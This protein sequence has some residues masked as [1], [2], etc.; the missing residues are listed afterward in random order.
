MIARGRL[1]AEDVDK[2]LGVLHTYSCVMDW[3][4]VITKPFMGSRAKRPAK[5]SFDSFETMR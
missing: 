1:R 2:L 5:I 4:K 3:L